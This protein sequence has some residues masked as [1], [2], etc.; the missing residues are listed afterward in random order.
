MSDPDIPKYIDI[1]F[2][3]V[4]TDWNNDGT[5]KD[6]DTFKYFGAR[7][8]K[9]EDFG[10]HNQSSKLYK[11]WEP[12]NKLCPDIKPDESMLLNGD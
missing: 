7:N 1:R 3:V 8:C 10:E 11:E 12:F 4:H 5:D 9:R 2:G 6:V